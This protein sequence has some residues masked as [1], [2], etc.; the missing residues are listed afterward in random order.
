MSNIKVVSVILKENNITLL[1]DKLKQYNFEVYVKLVRKFYNITQ[2][3]SVYIC[4]I[5]PV[6]VDFLPN[7][8]QQL[9]LSFKNVTS[10]L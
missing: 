1:G 6:I 7:I 5:D 3:T 8:S 9:E 4:N 10:Y 2:S